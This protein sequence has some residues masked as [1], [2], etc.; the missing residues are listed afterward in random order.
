MLSTGDRFENR[1][2]EDVLEIV[3]APDN[4]DRA[5]LVRRVLR[6]GDGKTIAHVHRDYGE[7]FVVE[8]GREE[9]PWSR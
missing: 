9:H 3:H 5:L 7:R 4:G 1:T 6:P 2:T 8:S